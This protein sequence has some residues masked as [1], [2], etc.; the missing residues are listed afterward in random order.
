MTRLAKTRI[1]SDLTFFNI[2]DAIKFTDKFEIR[3]FRVTRRSD[4]KVHLV[5]FDDTAYDE[6]DELDPFC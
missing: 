1:P 2:D 5:I 3:N 6:P 4:G